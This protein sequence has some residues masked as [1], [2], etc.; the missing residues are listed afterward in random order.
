MWSDIRYQ[1]SFPLLP[2]KALFLLFLNTHLDGERMVMRAFQKFE[3]LKVH[4]LLRNVILIFYWKPTMMDLF[5]ADFHTDFLVIPLLS[6]YV[7]SQKGYL[8]DSQKRI[9]LIA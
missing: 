5:K 2:A 6:I 7:G 3:R 9:K 1:L 4:C 8:P